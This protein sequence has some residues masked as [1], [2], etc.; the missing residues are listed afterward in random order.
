MIVVDKKKCMG[1]GLCAV[2]CHEQCITQ[3]RSNGNIV[4]KVDH[5]LCSTCVQCISV[6]PKRA[7]S[8]DETFPTS[9]ERSQL[10]SSVQVEELLKQRRTTRFFKDRKIDREVI[11]EIV[12]FGIYAPT[13]N[14]S[15]RAVLVDDPETIKALDAIIMKFV[16]LLYTA[17]YQFGPIYHFLKAVT[18][19]I[20]EKHRVKLEKGLQKGHSYD[21]LSTTMIFIVGDRRIPLSEASAQYALY[22]MILYAQTKKI[23]NRIKAAGSMT[24]DRSRKARKLL[25]L[26]EHEHILGTLELGYPRIK[27][28]NKVEGK[29]M[30]VQWCEVR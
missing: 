8:W 3:S 24:L 22:N 11:E 27:F 19:K 7:L 4:E 29:K 26:R 28:S 30:A 13:N 12:N 16:R 21:S 20:S 6:C 18:P 15:L 17:C 25:G 14:Y 5:A 10:P 9:F 2:V 1:C 23:G